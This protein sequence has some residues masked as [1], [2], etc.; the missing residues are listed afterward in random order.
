MAATLQE[1]DSA[2]ALVGA[3]LVS[4]ESSDAL[5]AYVALL[6]RWQQRINLIGPAD[7]REVWSRHVA[8]CLQLLDH[9]DSQGECLVD[10]GSGAG[11]PGLVLAIA[12]KDR[13]RAFAHLV[14]ANAKKA[15]FLREAVRVTG[16]PA[17][18]HAVR[19]EEIDSETLHPA[20]SLVTARAV[21]PLEKLVPLSLK[22]LK[23][24]VRAL[25][26]KGQHV[27]IELTKTS[28]YWRIQAENIPSPYEDGGIILKVEEVHR[29]ARQP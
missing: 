23:N 22:F 24:G 1:L 12:M 7:E 4:R 10:L 13:P 29:D 17:Q 14:D 19:I 25:F 26:L 28:K 8:D 6:M 2:E 5:A 3:G 21:A 18:V 20:P 11:L 16:A 9:I 15:A 27:D